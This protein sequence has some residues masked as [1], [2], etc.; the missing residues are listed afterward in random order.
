ML[1]EV[2]ALLQMFSI[3]SLSKLHQKC[4]RTNKYRII[5]SNTGLCQGKWKLATKL[6]AIKQVT[7]E[8]S[9]E[10]SDA[11]TERIRAMQYLSSAPDR[12]SYSTFFTFYANF[13]CN[14]SL[15]HQVLS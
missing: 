14:L 15:K 10:L 9:V 6:P 2:G 4:V 3:S 13:C 5:R 11:A 12:A 7:S 1:N 8:A